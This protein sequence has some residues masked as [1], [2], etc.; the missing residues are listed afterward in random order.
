M[1]G[2]W[3]EHFDWPIPVF[4]RFIRKITK[5]KYYSGRKWRCKRFYLK[6]R[7]IAEKQIKVFY[8]LNI[9]AKNRSVITVINGQKLKDP[10]ICSA[11]F[12][13]RITSILKFCSRNKALCKRTQHC[14]MLH[15]A[16]VCTTCCMLLRVVG[17]CFAKFETGHLCANSLQHFFCSVITKA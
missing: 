12:P 8:I 7:K 3:L 5:M 15:V 6:K 14:W 4:I 1:N 10:W 11:R 9:V 13:G 16:S 17:S 2:R